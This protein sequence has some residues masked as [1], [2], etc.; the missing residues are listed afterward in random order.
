MGGY[1]GSGRTVCVVIFPVKNGAGG[2]WFRR[3]IE[4][5]GIGWGGQA[6]V[7]TCRWGPRNDC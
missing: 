6:D 2:V 1:G 7:A 5:C 4:L 3:C